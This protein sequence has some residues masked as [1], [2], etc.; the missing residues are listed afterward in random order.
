MIAWRSRL[1]TVTFNENYDE[2]WWYHEQWVIDTSY[3][4]F[5]NEDVWRKIFISIENSKKLDK[6]EKKYLKNILE[7]FKNEEKLENEEQS[8]FLRL[9]QKDKNIIELIEDF[10]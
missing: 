2:Q 8:E 10:Y 3:T 7:K 6:D 4:E 9:I 1:R 5:E